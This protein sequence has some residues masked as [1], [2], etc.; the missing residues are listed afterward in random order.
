MVLLVFLIKFV[1]QYSHDLTQNLP[2]IKYFKTKVYC[3]LSNSFKFKFLITLIIG[4][5]I[6]SRIKKLNIIIGKSILK[7]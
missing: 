1:L 2:K 6:R 7:H 4:I 3:N 5:R